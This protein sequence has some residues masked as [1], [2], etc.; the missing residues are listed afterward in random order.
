MS[1]KKRLFSTLDDVPWRAL[2][3]FSGIGGIELGL[4]SLLNV[5]AMAEKDEFCQTILRR[6]FPGVKLF[7]DVQNINKTLFAESIDCIVGGFPCQDISQAGNRAGITGSKSGLVSEVYRLIEL[8]NPR[9]VIL[10]NVQ[11]LLIR[12]LKSVCDSLSGLG[13]DCRWMTCCCFDV[14]APHSRNRMFIFAWRRGTFPNETALNALYS[15]GLVENPWA[16]EPDCVRIDNNP[17]SRSKLAIKALGNAVVPQQIR[18]AMRTLLCDDWNDT[19]LN[20]EEDNL[21]RVGCCINGEYYSKQYEKT[22]CTQWAPT[23]QRFKATHSLPTPTAS[24]AILRKSTNTSASSAFRPGVNKSV[25][26]NRWVAMFPT[27]ETALPA[28][29]S[30]GVLVDNANFGGGI[31]PNYEWITWVMG[32]PLGWLTE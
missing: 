7:K 22:V 13:Y 19:V 6:R 32:F 28:I 20:R 23:L 27:R 16:V 2:S 29:D 21:S 25:S 26:I 1:E 14:G 9:F 30:K 24:D 10:E 11:T 15:D 5:V 31:V 17:S 18:F 12:G 8:L 4:S 3:L